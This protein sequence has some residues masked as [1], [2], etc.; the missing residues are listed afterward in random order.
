MCSGCVDG[1]DGLIARIETALAWE[2]RFKL[3]PYEQRR[4]WDHQLWQMT[5]AMYE[6]EK[7]AGP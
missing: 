2:H 4:L 3:P 6:R 5:T 1:A 7:G